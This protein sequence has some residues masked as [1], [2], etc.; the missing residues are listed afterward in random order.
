MPKVIQGLRIKHRARKRVK[1]RKLRTRW[2]E[3]PKKRRRSTRFAARNV[4][5]CKIW[6]LLM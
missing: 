4:K 5:S 2:L 1:A 3:Y 6:L